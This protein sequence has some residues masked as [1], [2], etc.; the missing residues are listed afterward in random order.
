MSRRRALPHDDLV[1]EIKTLVAQANIAAS[2]RWS[3]D[4]D[5]YY[6]KVADFSP[7][8]QTVDRYA[9]SMKEAKALAATL[10]EIGPDAA[11]AVAKGLRMRGGFRDLLVPFVRQHRGLAVIHETLVLVAARREDPFAAEARRILEEG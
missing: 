1:R 8:T 9:A 3:D 6:V 4:M 2:T 7:M 10:L 5:M 11:A